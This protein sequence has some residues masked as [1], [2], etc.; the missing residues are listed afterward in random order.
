MVPKE[1]RRAFLRSAYN[2]DQ[3]VL[4]SMLASSNRKHDES[5]KRKIVRAPSHSII[6]ER[7][8]LLRENK[9][10]ARFI[11]K[12]N[13]IDSVDERLQ[14]NALHWAVE[15]KNKKVASILVDH[16]IDVNAVDK[17]GQTALHIVSKHKNSLRLLLLLLD[18]GAQLN[19]I[20]KHGYTPLM[21]ATI[22]GHIEVV[23][24]LLSY[25]ADIFVETEKNYQKK[26]VMDFA[27]DSK[28]EKILQLLLH[29][30]YNTTNE[31]SN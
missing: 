13:L 27:S 30:V 7:K 1:V 26:T 16:G 15:Q 19:V 9:E 17:K 24:I 31:F 8:R 22:N 5:Y 29:H 21:I 18:E 10:L 3:K 2:G 4:L 12:H 25:G 6:F 20:D 28:E 14:R 23:K 11:C